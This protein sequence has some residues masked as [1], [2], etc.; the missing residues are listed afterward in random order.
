[1][2]GGT[3]GDWRIPLIKFLKGE[4]RGETKEAERI[5]RKICFYYLK[6][7]ELYRRTLLSSDAKCMSPKEVLLVL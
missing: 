6:E 7:G 1:M 3:D 5:E 2:E 4:W